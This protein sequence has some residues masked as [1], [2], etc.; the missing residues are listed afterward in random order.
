MTS[1]LILYKVSKSAIASHSLTFD[2]EIRA[3]SFVLI[4]ET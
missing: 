3:Q 2:P 4:Y 1:K